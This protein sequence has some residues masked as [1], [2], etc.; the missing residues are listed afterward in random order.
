[1]L[2]AG[3]CDRLASFDLEPGESYC[4]PIALGSQIRQGL[5]PRVQMRMTFDADQVDLGGSPGVITT[6]DAEADVQRLLDEAELRPIEPLAFDALADMEMGDGRERNLIYAASPSQADSESFLVIISL[7]TDD[8][9]E[10]RLLRP[11]LSD[12]DGEVP[13]ERRPIFGLFQLTRRE[14]DCGF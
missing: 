13:P 10:V 6:F 14:G 5:T 8:V 1:L 7:R 9:V 4:G 12:V 3:G 11:G 2:A